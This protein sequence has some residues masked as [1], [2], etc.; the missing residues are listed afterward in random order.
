V[1]ERPGPAEL[2]A[3]RAFVAEHHA[4]TP[5]RRL[6]AL[7]AA[8]GCHVHV[9]CENEAAVRSFKGRGPLW[10]MSRLTGAERTRGVVT[11][12]TGNHGQGVASAGGLL[13]IRTIVVVP[14]S[15]PA[16]KC[17][18][19]RALGGTVQIVPGDLAH[20][21]ETARAR[22]REDDLHYLEDGED[23]GLMA[24]A[25][26]V[27]WEIL[28]DLPDTDAIVVPVGGGN[29]IAGIALVAKQLNPAI[30]LIG[31]QS[32]AAPAA[33]RSW[34]AREIVELPCA[35]RAG[36]LATSYP[37]GLALSVMIEL[38]D[39][40]HLVPEGELGQHVVAVLA[41]TGSL[42]ELAAAAPFALLGRLAPDLAGR[43][44]V[45]IQSGGNLPLEELAELLASSRHLPRAAT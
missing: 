42:I 4:R 41:A 17:D 2:L 1:S 7:S 26:S 34:Q 39:E 28:D 6:D 9:K 22:A 36:G 44:V 23:P 5:L 40:M 35:T 19:I 31:V 38:V 12:S 33:V 32:D 37:G 27:A 14:E 45:L 10:S 25:G 30:R 20:A 18:R 3:A 16:L 43:R 11:A 13:G 15:T 21:T 24:G 8:T 29:L